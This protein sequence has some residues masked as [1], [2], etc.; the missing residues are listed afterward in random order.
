MS[1]TTPAQNKKEPFTCFVRLSKDSPRINL[2]KT[3]SAIRG[4]ILLFNNFWNCLFLHT[5]PSQQFAGSGYHSRM[6]ELQAYESCNRPSRPARSLMMTLEPLTCKKFFFLKSANSRVTVSRDAP[7]I[8]AISSCVSVKL[9]L[10][11]P[12]SAL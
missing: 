5:F 11:D 6:E 7:I 10:T 4:I 8:C 12:F 2:N 9:N 1:R 3:K